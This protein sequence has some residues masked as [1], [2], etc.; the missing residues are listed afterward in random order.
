MASV[1][2][3]TSSPLVR[4]VLKGMG[5]WG[6]A[7]IATIV[8]QLA[9]LPI[10]LSYWSIE[11]YGTW[12]TISTIPSYLVLA[13]F[14]FLT[15][16]SNKMIALE[17]VGKHKEANV[18]FQSGVLFILGVSA[19]IMLLAVLG[20]ETASFVFPKFEQYSSVVLVLTGAV[21]VS[22]VG[23][24]AQTVF[25]ATQGFAAGTYLYTIARVLDWLGSIVGLVIGGSF[26][27]VALCGTI[28]RAVFTLYFIYLSHHRRPEIKWGLRHASA[29][30]LRESLKP[31]SLFLIFPLASALSLQ[32]FIVLVTATLGPAAT[33]IFSSYRTI[34][35]IVVQCAAALSQSMWP[36]FS[37]M[38]STQEVARLRRTY[39]NAARLSSAIGLAA[40][41]TVLAISPLLIAYWSK[42]H[43]T[44]SWSLMTAFMVYSLIASMWHVPRVMLMSINQHALLARQYFTFSVLSLVLGV[45]LAKQMGLMGPVL[46]MVAG[47]VAMWLASRRSVSNMWRGAPA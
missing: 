24:L 9:S 16:T 39:S 12:L 2:S 13:D 15:A 18:T 46:A 36:E 17:A 5:A 11:T 45:L 30:E 4:R 40:S 10:F 21:V 20:M 27:S 7:Q 41:L 42:G 33:A 3:L 6:S 29:R 37:H 31:A 1:K 32:G 26:M 14:G 25:I 8:I 38:H 19:V 43:I 28:C 23:S 47:E 35:R 34:A 44:F 22:L